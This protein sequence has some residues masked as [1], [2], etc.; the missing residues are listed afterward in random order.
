MVR[1]MGV[2]VSVST[3]TSARSCVHLLFVAHAEAVLFIDDEQ[4][5]VVELGRFTEQLVRADHD[6]H[7]AVA[8]ALDGRRDLLAGA[9]A[10]DLGNLDWPLGEAVH[11]RLV[12]LLGQQR[13]GRKKG[14]LPPARDGHEGRAQGH[15]GLAEAHVAANQAVHGAGADHVL[16][17]GVDGGVLVGCFFE[18]EVVGKGLVVLRRVA[19]GVALARGAAGVDVEQ[20][21]RAVAHLACRLALGLFPLAA[22]QLVQRRLVRA[23]AGVAADELQLAHRHIQHGL[24]GIFEVQ[25]LLQRGRAIGVLVA[26]IHVDEAPVAADAV[27]AVHHGVAHVELAQIFDERVYIAH[28]LLLFAP[29]R[30]GAGG[31][32][33]GLGH[34]VDA[35]LDPA[36]AHVEPGGGNAHLLGGIALELGQRVEGRRVQPAGA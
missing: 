4:A 11:Q 16:D 6:V 15:F 13:G 29:A 3:S 14:H 19:E 5:Q 24:V 23:H 36:E 10:R 20:F 25:K 17:D 35:V 9:K 31:E 32:K 22:A 30:G 27:L 33:L 8:N 12:V 7:R 28:L 26:H 21:G 34:E 1:G 2:A 18:A